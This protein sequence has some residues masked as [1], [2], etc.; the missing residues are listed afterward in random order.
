MYNI[1]IYTRQTQQRISQNV[2]L[3][4]VLD[5]MCCTTLLVQ[6][7]MTRCF[8]SLHEDMRNTTLCRSIYLSFLITCLPIQ[9]THVDTQQ[10]VSNL[11]ATVAHPNATPP[12]PI[13]DFRKHPSHVSFHF[14]IS[15]RYN[16][17]IESMQRA[18]PMS[19]HNFE[20][21]MNQ[22]FDKSM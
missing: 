19:T 2:R 17:G 11:K 1:Y 5:N 20:V 14:G 4:K 21:S 15:C 10:K 12:A 7:E 16:P 13:Q 3:S 18:P 8:V 9:L 22:E 6:Y